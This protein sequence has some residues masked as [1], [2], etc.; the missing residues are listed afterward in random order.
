[1]S[2]PQHFWNLSNHS[3]KKSWPDTQ[4][5]AAEAWAGHSRPLILEDVPFPQIDP[6]M[7]SKRVGELAQEFVSNLEARGCR[8]GEPILVQGEFTFVVAIVPLLQL[9]GLVPLCATSLRM[10]CEVLEPDGTVTKAYR[11][12]FA[13]FREYISYPIDPVS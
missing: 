9:I 8:Q 5:A 4:R 10:G 13:T 12:E 3:V 2:F 1:M 7:D 6:E 11:F